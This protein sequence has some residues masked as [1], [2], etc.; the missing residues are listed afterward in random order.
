MPGIGPGQ[1]YAFRASGPFSPEHG[2]RFDPDKV[3]LDPY[4][5]AV[6]VPD[7][8]SRHLASRRGD[9][10]AIAMKSVVVDPGQYDWEGDAPLR[11]S[12]ATTVIYEMHVAGFTHHPSS[13]VTAE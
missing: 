12:F 1:V 11:R 13:R 6:L 4:G 3:L 7:I 10:T 5:R 9:N 2:L 8:Y